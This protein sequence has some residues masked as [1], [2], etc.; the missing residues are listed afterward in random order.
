VT[1]S[2]DRVPTSRCSRAIVY[3]GW[4]APFAEPCV[5]ST[6]LSTPTLNPENL[7]VILAAATGCT[8]RLV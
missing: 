1:P 8:M 5:P 6:A 7:P 2:F 4:P 3:T